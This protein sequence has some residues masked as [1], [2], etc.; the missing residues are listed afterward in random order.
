MI[1]VLLQLGKAQFVGEYIAYLENFVPSSLKAESKG[2]DIFKGYL[3]EQGAFPPSEIVKLCLE[4]SSLPN[5]SDNALDRLRALDARIDYYKQNSNFGKKSQHSFVETWKT[6]TDPNNLKPIDNYLIAE[7]LC[8]QTSAA[9]RLKGIQHLYAAATHKNTSDECVKLAK[10]F[11]FGRLFPAEKMPHLIELTIP[12]EEKNS[13]K[14][15]DKTAI[16]TVQSL[17]EHESNEQSIINN[18][19]KMGT[20]YK[21]YIAELTK[22]VVDERAAEE[23]RTRQETRQKTLTTLNKLPL[24]LQVSV[25]RKLKEQIK[26]HTPFAKL[27]SKIISQHQNLINLAIG[28]T[29]PDSEV[30]NG[31][32]SEIKHEHAVLAQLLTEA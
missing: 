25:A 21:A 27:I 15:S 12:K 9:K 16:N 17:N 14:H 18:P 20:R 13:E 29:G 8:V 30:R 4:N 2:N 7:Y 23:E 32:L 1:R 3:I 31:I 26:H 22:E 19:K 10:T 5:L 6:I 24:K 11:L 28:K